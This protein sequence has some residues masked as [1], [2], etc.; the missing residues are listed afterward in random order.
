MTVHESVTKE[1]D[2]L[3]SWWRMYRDEYPQIAAAARDYLIVL[4]SKVVVER[5]FNRGRDLL[6]VQ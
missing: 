1:K 6:G 3:F 2:W 5:L 4:A